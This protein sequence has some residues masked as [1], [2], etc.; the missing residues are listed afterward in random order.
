MLCMLADMLKGENGEKEDK[1]KKNA[2]FG[3]SNLLRT[4]H[5]CSYINPRHAKTIIPTLQPSQLKKERRRLLFFVV[6]SS[7]LFDLD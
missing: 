5:V 6:S 1:K 4:R 7:A 3:N 2:F